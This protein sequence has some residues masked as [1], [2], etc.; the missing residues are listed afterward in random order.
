MYIVNITV[1]PFTSV[2]MDKG[3]SSFSNY[4]CHWMWIFTHKTKKTPKNIYAKQDDVACVK[5]NI[6]MCF[7]AYQLQR[8][9]LKM[10]QERSFSYFAQDQMYSQEEIHWYLSENATRAYF[11]HCLNNSS[12]SLASCKEPTRA[13]GTLDEWIHLL[14]CLW[15]HTGLVQYHIYACNLSEMCTSR[16]RLMWKIWSY[17]SQHQKS[18]CPSSSCF[19]YKLGTSKC[20]AA[21]SAKCLCP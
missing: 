10:Q 15:L 7:H 4:C 14:N 11:C 8:T 16:K 1:F 18:I 13:K 6:M 19:D 17:T 2:E 21:Y 12:S 20:M 9:N 3:T 5:Q